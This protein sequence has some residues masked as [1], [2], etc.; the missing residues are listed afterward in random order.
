MDDLY[1]V[2]LYTF[3]LAR[4]EIFQDGMESRF[5]REL[6]DYLSAD[7]PGTLRVIERLVT[8][9]K[10]GGEEL[11]EAC[12]WLGH[13]ETRETHEQRRG[14]LESLLV[15]PNHYVKDGAML[16]LSFLDDPAAIP[17]LQA[18]AKS[19]VYDELRQDMQDVIDDLVATARER[20]A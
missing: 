2:L 5:S 9:G 3:R 13:D 18:A 15:H 11:G 1:E 16:G 8:E 4:E 14:L 6:E 19:E 7:G 12:R 17:A 20:E 10:I